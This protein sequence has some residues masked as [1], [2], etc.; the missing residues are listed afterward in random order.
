[1]QKNKN[2]G[3]S[4]AECD[5]G[6]RDLPWIDGFSSREVPQEKAGNMILTPTSNTQLETDNLWPIAWLQRLIND[7]SQGLQA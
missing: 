7:E 4:W 2:R 3:E 6:S 1:M 5:S